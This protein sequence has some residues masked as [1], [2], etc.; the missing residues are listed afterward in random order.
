[1]YDRLGSTI[2]DGCMIDEIDRVQLDVDKLAKD[3]LGKCDLDWNEP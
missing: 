3:E 2:M 1:M